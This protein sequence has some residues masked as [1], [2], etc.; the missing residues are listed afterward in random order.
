MSPKTILQIY[1]SGIFNLCTRSEAIRYDHDK[2]WSKTSEASGS[3]TIKKLMRFQSLGS[4]FLLFTHLIWS[5]LV[6]C[7][8]P[9]C[10]FFVVDLDE[11]LKKTYKQFPLKLS[12][13]QDKIRFFL[14]SNLTILFLLETAFI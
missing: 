3:T 11:H 12:Q 1:Y 14:F 4:A 9:V 6:R 13:S 7:I 10:V 5:I 8:F 2:S